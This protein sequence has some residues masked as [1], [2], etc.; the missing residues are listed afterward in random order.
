ME[1]DVSGMPGRD[2]SRGLKCSF[3]STAGTG[4]SPGPRK[5]RGAQRK[6]NF[7]QTKLSF[8]VIQGSAGLGRISTNQKQARNTDSME[9]GKA[10][11]KMKV[12]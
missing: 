4:T 1:T 10:V 9:G 11:K 8:E 7:T 12:L 3:A 5:G 2:T 6:L